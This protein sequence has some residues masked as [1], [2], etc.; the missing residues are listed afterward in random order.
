[1]HL[2][3]LSG[4]FRP[5]LVALALLVFPSLAS[6][7]AVVTWG[8][9]TG[10]VTSSINSQRGVGVLSLSLSTP[11]T[12][13][14]PSYT[15]APVFGG[16]QAGSGVSITVHRIN[17]NHVVSGDGNDLYDLRHTTSTTGIMTA[18]VLWE[19]PYLTAALPGGTAKNL[20]RLKD[21]A[22]TGGATPCPSPAPAPLAYFVVRY[23][24]GGGSHG[25]M[26]AQTS[27]N[28]FRMDSNGG[29]HT[30]DASTANWYDYDPTT[31]AG[32]ANIGAATLVADPNLI[33]EGVTHVGML[34]EVPS[35][36]I[37]CSLTF[38][39]F[40]VT[41]ENWRKKA[42][43]KAL[44]NNDT[45]N[46]EIFDLR[47]DGYTGSDYDKDKFNADKLRL[48][49]DEA[50]DVAD[51][52]NNGVD[53]YMISPGYSHVPLWRSAEID[54]DNHFAWHRYAHPK[55]GTNKLS[56]IG[57]FMDPSDSVAD[58]GGDVVDVVVDHCATRG[59]ASFVSFRVNDYHR[60]QE[61]DA[62]PG[63]WDIASL[64]DLS[65]S[66]WR[67]ENPQYRLGRAAVSTRPEYRVGNTTPGYAAHTSGWTDRRFAEFMGY[68]NDSVCLNWAIED[69][70][71]RTFNLIADV[72]AANPGMSGLELDFP[73]AGIYFREAPPQQNISSGE[74]A[75]RAQIM[76]EFVRDVRL[77]LDLKGR[78]L[79]RNYW[80]SVRMPHTMELAYGADAGNEDGKDPDGNDQD[81]I[82]VRQLAEEGVDMF[83][84][85]SRSTAHSVQVGTRVRIDPDLGEIIAAIRAINPQAAIYYEL[86]YLVAS[87]TEYDS[88]GA[89]ITNP[90]LRWSAGREQLKTAMHLAYSGAGT[91]P[92]SGS[93]GRPWPGGIDGFS[94]Y[95]F[96]FYRLITVSSSSTGRA[97]PPFDV[98]PD[99]K[100]PVALAASAQHYFRGNATIRPVTSASSATTGMFTL[101]L[102]K[103]ST[104]SGN[105]TGNA[106]L[107]LHA[108]FAIP[109]G[110]TFSAVLV[111]STNVTLT[112]VTTPTVPFPLGSGAPQFPAIGTVGPILEWSIDTAHLEEGVNTFKIIRTD[113]LSTAFHF[114]YAD[115]SIP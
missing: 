49:I 83:V 26:I 96:A 5:A 15:G 50:V 113:S 16:V 11:M 3:G 54:P 71:I 24:K 89:V 36:N 44:Y 91:I 94:L 109:P 80:L 99:L 105:W 70:R 93:P 9:S 21:F 29:A 51:G 39:K 90:Q 84:F 52:T 112:P 101:V 104:N 4:T 43:F 114:G 85:C 10:Y 73:R 66:L 48:S 1:M 69:V 13:S 107:R 46:V 47:R 76:R 110:V 17:N 6:A 53:A 103:P 77:L 37:D 30:L 12:P 100:D 38:Y 18:L 74:R 20:V 58:D 61:V 108:P 87:R 27:I 67:F 97:E 32:L 25:Y 72:L 34:F 55:T 19:N 42:P 8:P 59:I 86:T 7:V 78:Q 2:T 60:G 63:L 81:G 23:E 92:N 22:Y 102:R 56:A 111:K 115:F 75:A 68:A 28:G 82:D 35:R 45:G 88:S 79:N 57:Y 98:I 106:R 65:N 95:N 62:R 33:L 40:S 41:A 64:S 31:G 14:S